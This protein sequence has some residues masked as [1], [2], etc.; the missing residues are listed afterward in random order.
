MLIRHAIP[1]FISGYFSTCQRSPKTLAA[2]TSDLKQF[3]A[4]LPRSARLSDVVPESIER[5][6]FALKE[7]GYAA[8]S[9]RRKLASVT[10]FFNYWVRRR[11]L[12]RSPLWQL[13]L[14][15]GGQR[16]LTRTL[17]QHEVHRLLVEAD[18]AASLGGRSAEMNRGFLALRNRAIVE[19]M[20]ATGMRVGEVAS[21]TT[22]D[23]LEEQRAVVVRGKGDRQRLAFLVDDR[24]YGVMK[25]YT[26]S[27]RRVA[28]NCRALFVNVFSCPLSA[29]GAAGVVSALARRAGIARRV[30][31]HML[32]HS[33]ATLLLS[34]GADI[35]IVQEFL[36]HASISTTQRY[37]H[38]SKE[39]LLSKLKVTHPNLVCPAG[40]RPRLRP[41]SPTPSHRR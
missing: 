8:T 24:S 30:T 22:A 9:I 32:R 20:F 16:L 17:S 37:T 21:L 12:D 14:D 13:R 40:T 27:R 26:A 38:V 35:R 25:R 5:W 4:A 41:P 10:A 15:L 7:E 39:H 2:Y 18:V 31:P 3:G 11:A 19:L 29:Q 23:F 1:A 33:V 6:A 28:T 34:N 36:G